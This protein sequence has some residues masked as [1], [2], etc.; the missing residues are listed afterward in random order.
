MTRKFNRRR[1]PDPQPVVLWRIDGVE[2]VEI[3]PADELARRK[4]EAEWQRYRRSHGLDQWEEHRKLALRRGAT[5]TAPDYTGEL[6]WFVLDVNGLDR[7]IT[8]VTEIFEQM[9]ERT[10]PFDL[11]EPVTLYDQWDIHE[12]TRVFGELAGRLS[13]PSRKASQRAA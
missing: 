8:A 7:T 2:P 3:V 1:R 5:I 10:F 13:D 6:W 4:E 11:V 9:R 12:A